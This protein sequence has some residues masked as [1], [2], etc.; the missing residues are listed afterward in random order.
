MSCCCTT[1]PPSIALNGCL[2]RSPAFGGQ[3]SA[4]SG[5][6]YPSFWGRKKLLSIEPAGSDSSNSNNKR[7]LMGSASTNN[8]NQWGYRRGWG[9]GGWGGGWSGAQAQ[10]QAQSGGHGGGGW[11]GA[12]VRHVL[13]HVTAKNLASRFTARSCQPPIDLAVSATMMLGCWLLT[14][15]CPFLSVPVYSVLLLHESVTGFLWVPRL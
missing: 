14:A 5:S 2:E 15:D 3:A 8:A 11:S 10:A 12:Q 1:R 7:T 13:N 6:F 9:G 4:G